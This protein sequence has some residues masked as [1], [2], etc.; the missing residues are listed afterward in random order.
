MIAAVDV[1][2]G[3][4]IP[5]SRQCA[6]GCSLWLCVFLALEPG[7]LMRWQ[8]VPPTW[9]GET[10]RMAL[11]SLLFG[12]CGPIVFGLVRIWPLRSPR[13]GREVVWHAA[14]ITVLSLVFLTIANIMAGVFLNG[15]GIRHLPQE[16]AANFTLLI[17]SIAALDFIVHFIVPKQVD[18]GYS[19]HIAVKS[20]QG[21]FQLPLAHVERLEAQE[22]YVALHTSTDT[23]LV[24]VTLSSLIKDLDP[25]LFTRIHRGVVINRAYVEKIKPAENGKLQIILR[26]GAEAFA[27]RAYA[28]TLRDF[29]N[30]RP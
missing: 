9:S 27:S 5:W 29:W 25:S 1:G 16:I 24:R 21:R 22:N 20:R 15:P 6:I 8:G 19:R 11:A 28:R 17:A 12:T 18:P 7:N 3:R 14:A 10:L 13:L 26:S 30:P 2:L 23:Y 4:T